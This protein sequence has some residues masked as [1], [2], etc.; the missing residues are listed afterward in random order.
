MEGY[1]SSIKRYYWIIVACTLLALIGGFVLSFNQ[2]PAY[3]VTSIMLVR[4]GAPGSTY[5]GGPSSGATT[6]D[7]LGEALNYAAEIPTRTVMQYVLQ[8]DP[9]IQK[10]GFTADDLIL[11]VVSS[12]STTAA[13]INLLA[14][15]RHPADAVLIA[16][17]VAAGFADYI[18]AQNQQQLDKERT[19][20]TN[21]I[22][23]AQQQQSVWQAKIAALPS[24]TTPQYTVYNSELTAT[25]ST[26]SSLNAQLQALPTTVNGDVTVIQ[27]AAP[28]DVTSSAKGVIIVAVAGGVGLFVG[29]L[30]M[31]LVIFL[32]HRL[33]SYEQVNEKL[34]L[35]YL[36]NVSKS[37]ELQKAPT[38]RP[39]SVLAHELSDICANLRLTGVLSG[40]WEAPHGAVLLITSPQAAEGK[41][42]LTAA[43]ATS[44]ASTGGRVVVVDGNLQQP[45]THL[46]FEMSP[47]G[48]GL[49][50]LLKGTGNE[51]IDDA[52]MR[53]TIPGV[54]L[55]P[56]G[57]PTDSATLLLGPRFAKVVQQLRQKADLIIIDGPPLLSGA[58]ASQMASMVDGVA[59]VVDARY[60]KLPLIMRAKDLLIS[61]AHTPAG[62][63][64]NR[65]TTR[66]KNGYYASTYS[67]NAVAGREAS[68]PEYIGN[69][70]GNG[71][72]NGY[73][74]E[75]Q[76]AAP[77]AM[78]SP[79][80][81]APVPP[82]PS[83]GLSAPGYSVPPQSVISW[84][85][86]RNQ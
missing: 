8:F 67:G 73:R 30:V 80:P 79:F 29:L 52:V 77:T 71:A 85:P 63:I 54:W 16:N 13:T 57:A 23:T 32:D 44:V 55:L 53:S 64:M 22:K 31:L 43:L 81:P 14:T 48:I 58:S 84:E 10:R 20:L 49:G 38:A 56:A 70:N 1:F 12:T 24:T 62:I 41:T 2:P 45:S 42:T 46:V 82:I 78:K 3:Q 75:P 36:G 11:D 15:A 19:N 83:I 65:S 37:D 39:T 33:N 68:V 26:L 7:S 27:Q 50:G 40:A 86:P 4:A 21:E 25:T 74:P 60:A 18:R 72:H 47:A 9:Q 17:G 51:A 35:A 34:G 5:P 61:L 69:G 76:I 66:R 28:K 6:S 59:L